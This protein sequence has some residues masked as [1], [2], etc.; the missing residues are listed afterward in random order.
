MH[1]SSDPTPTDLIKDFAKF[2]ELR[3]LDSYH[4]VPPIVLGVIVCLVG[5][6]SALVVGFFLST[7][8]CWHGTYFINSL[9]HLFGRRRYVTTDTSRNSLVLALLTFG[10]GWHNNHHYYQSSAN[11]G[12]FWWEID[13]S[14]YV[15]KAAQLGRSGA[16]PAHAA[17]ARAGREPHPGRPRRHRHVPGEL[18]QG[19]RATLENAKAHAGEYYEERRRAL[20]QLVDTHHAGRASRSRRCRPSRRPS[21][22]SV[23]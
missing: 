13:V 18:G 21:Q 17:R 15:L 12:F 14:Y 9:A 11:Q 1:A 2:P 7:V 22:R 23:R 8:L 20:D 16:R 3:W 4:L 10:E 19:R 6:W 5:G